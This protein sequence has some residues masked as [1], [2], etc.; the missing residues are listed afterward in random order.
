MQEINEV[1]HRCNNKKEFKD[2]FLHNNTKYKENKEKANGFN[3]YYINVCPELEK[4]LPQCT[5][6]LQHSLPWVDLP[7]TFYLTPTTP[8]EVESVITN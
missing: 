1:I 2:N 3:N 6:Q 4:A 8:D 7:H 5:N